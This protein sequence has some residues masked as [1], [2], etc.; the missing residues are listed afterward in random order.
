MRARPLR[1]PAYYRHRPRGLTEWPPDRPSS[2]PR[3]DCRDVTS[4]AP[5]RRAARI[6]EACVLRN[7]PQAAARED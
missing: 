6:H 5:P 3:R 2:A 7:L 4:M 1:K